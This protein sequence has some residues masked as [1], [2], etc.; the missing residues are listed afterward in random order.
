MKKA[1]YRSIP[2]YFDRH[3]NLLIGRNWFYDLL[4]RIN[5]WL[6]YNVLGIEDLPVYIQEDEEE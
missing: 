1:T 3:T 4:V 5:I 6:D 2:C